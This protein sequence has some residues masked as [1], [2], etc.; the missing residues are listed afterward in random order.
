[1]PQPYILAI[2]QGT[3]SSRALVVDAAGTV[4][5]VGQQPF[6]QHFP[7]PGWVEHDA[8]DIWKTTLAAIAQA[9]RREH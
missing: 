4:C 5:G 1:M 3:T 2:D 9:P 7:Q 8:D 6:D